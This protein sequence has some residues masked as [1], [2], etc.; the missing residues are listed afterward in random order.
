MQSFILNNAVDENLIK[1]LI[2]L[3]SICSDI[4]ERVY[5]EGDKLI[6]ILMK[7]PAEAKVLT[8]FMFVRGM[9]S[10]IYDTEL[11]SVLRYWTEV[12]NKFA[13][14]LLGDLYKNNKIY[15][16]PYNKL[17]NIINQP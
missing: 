5:V 3:L 8:E 4:E 10:S 17:Y 6:N 11:V 2:E 7:Y 15:L 9:Y 13:N 1:I 16:D 12:D 14:K